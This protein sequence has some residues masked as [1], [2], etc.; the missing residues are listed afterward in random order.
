MATTKKASTSDEEVMPNVHAEAYAERQRAPGLYEDPTI[1]TPG[2]LEDI[3][4]D[5]GPTALVSAEDPP[6]IDPPLDPSVDNR[7]QVQPMLD[8][9]YEDAVAQREAQAEA[10]PVAAVPAS[11][12]AKSDDKK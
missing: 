3:E 7:D 9:L 2:I 12:T 10:T 5:A 11:S 4:G 6:G 8:K 1:A